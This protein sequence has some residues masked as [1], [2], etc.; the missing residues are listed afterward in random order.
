MDKK[1]V[2]QLQN[3]NPVEITKF[4]LQN[5]KGAESKLR[6]IDHLE[7]G[8]EGLIEPLDVVL[9]EHPLHDMRKYAPPH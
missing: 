9:L 5:L 3:E 6:E 2:P 1:V 8:D 7:I 4:Y